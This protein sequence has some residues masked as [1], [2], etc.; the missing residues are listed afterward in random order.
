MVR[1]N[2][3]WGSRETNKRKRLE[4]EQRYCYG[5]LE[6][7][8]LSSSADS[9]SSE[10]N[11]QSFFSLLNELKDYLTLFKELESHDNPIIKEVG[12]KAMNRY[13]SEVAVG[14]ALFDGGVSNGKQT[15]DGLKYGHRKKLSEAYSTF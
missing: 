10:E 8:L 13:L 4:E 6:E 7:Q 14:L 11:E 9:S 1:K 2:R 3:K 5:W 15:Q 12:T